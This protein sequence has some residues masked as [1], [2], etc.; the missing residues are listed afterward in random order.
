MIREV[1]S[2]GAHHIRQDFNVRLLLKKIKHESFVL[3]KDIKIFRHQFN[4][5]KE[6]CCLLKNAD[7]LLS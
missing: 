7:I 1:L 5:L 4:S 3:M 6:K 2:L